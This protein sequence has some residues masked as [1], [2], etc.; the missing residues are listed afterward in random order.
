M[1]CEP[2]PPCEPP[3]PFFCEPLGSTNDGKRIVVEDSAS[4]QR[5]IP[6][7][8]TPAILAAENDGTLNWKGGNAGSVLSYTASGIKFV[9]GSSSEPF[10]LSSLQTHT[11]D[12]VPNV[13]VML[14]DG[15]VKKWDPT[16]VGNNFLA[17]WDGTNWRI[18]T[19]NS[20]LPAGNGS[21]FIRDNS[22]NLQAIS[23]AAN[24]ILKIVGSTPAFVTSSSSNPFPSGH[25]YGL[26]LSN[27]ITNPNTSID[28]SSGE[29]RDSSSSENIVLSSTITKSETGAFV[30]GTGQPG[31]LGGTPSPGPNATLHVLIIAGASG[32]DIGFHANPTI[33]L[34]S[35]P[36]GYNQYYRRIGS[37]ITDAA[38]NIERFFQNGDRFLLKTPFKSASTR[39]Q[40]IAT[41]GTLISLYVP[42]GIKVQPFIRALYQVATLKYVSFYDPDQALTSYPMDNIP[43]STEY[44]S[45]MYSNINF[46]EIGQN[47]EMLLT[48]TNRQ[49]GAIMSPSAGNISWDIWGWA[50]QRN[51]LQP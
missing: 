51:R 48:N 49:I 31:L 35:L 29:C 3:F 34:A 43:T 21:V 18:N 7:N 28:V 24:D 6:T 12:N 39:A 17:Y 32:V 19:L 15:T 10:Q 1:P 4:C 11:P 22:G 30:A 20:L 47:N 41:T 8:P 13:I 25:I 50:D 16:N 37:I 40:S 5:T 36:A 23:G 26:I 38:G 44:I 9:N 14:S 45:S 42:S 46:I 2:T 27:N 33:A